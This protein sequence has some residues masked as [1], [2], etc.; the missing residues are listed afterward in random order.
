MKVVERANG[1]IARGDMKG[2]KDQI[3]A[4]ARTERMFKGVVGKTT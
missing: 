2:L 4:L 3:E 1:M